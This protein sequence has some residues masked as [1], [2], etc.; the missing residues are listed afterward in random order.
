[1]KK[2]I[3]IS[4]AIPLILLLPAL[5]GIVTALEAGDPLDHQVVITGMVEM[6]GDTFILKEADGFQYT[7][8]NEDLSDLVG[9]KVR[10]TGELILDDDVNRFNVDKIVVL[11]A[12]KFRRY[13]PAEAGQR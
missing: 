12:K 9:K 5:A 4:I 10:A 2:I 7:I 3:T 13:L 8:P 6:Q 11:P 1:M